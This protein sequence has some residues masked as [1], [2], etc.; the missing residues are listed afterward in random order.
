MGAGWGKDGGYNKNPGA[1]PLALAGHY[2]GIKG[3]RAITWGI[4]CVRKCREGLF[5]AGGVTP[6]SST[7]AL[8]GFGVGRI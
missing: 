7:F 4:Q 3:A 1:I 5:R 8:K 6:S 2:F